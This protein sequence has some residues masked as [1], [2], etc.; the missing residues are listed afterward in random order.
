MIDASPDRSRAVR[1]GHLRAVAIPVKEAKVS[2]TPHHGKAHPAG[3]RAPGEPVTIVMLGEPVAYARTAGGKTRVRYTPPRQRDA[4]ARLAALA[5]EERWGHPLLAGPLSLEVIAE[6][7]VPQSWSKKRQAAVLGAWRTGRPDYDNLAKLAA[8]AL[9]GIVY[10][11]DS[12]IVLAG[13][14]KLYGAKPQITVT[15]RELT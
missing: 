4:A 14:S 3:G 5:Q 1:S 11:D 2:V 13:I 9:T 15:I 12:Q 8:D 6:F 10:K 7:G